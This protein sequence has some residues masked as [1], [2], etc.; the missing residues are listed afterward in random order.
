MNSSIKTGCCGDGAE[1]LNAEG[2]LRPRPGRRLEDERESDL[3]GEVT[4]L[5]VVVREPV[6][7]A[8][9]AGLAQ[10]VL[11]PRLVAEVARGL[12]AHPPDSQQLARLGEWDLQ[13]LVRAVESVDGAEVAGE[14]ARRV[15]QLP[16]VEDVFDAPVGRDTVA[17]VLGQMLLRVL[18]DDSD[19]HARL[20]H[21]RLD[22]AVG[23]IGEI[24]RGEYHEVHTAPLL[25]KRRRESST[26]CPSACR[27]GRLR[28]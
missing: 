18:A 5:C 9:D 14:H 1:I 19:A 25:I 4:A 7:R 17:Q 12:D 6:A 15:R 21:R 8:G 13:L 22:E 16:R 2:G 3:F 27:H 11:H 20:A 28:S 24:R 10:H 23:V 26:L